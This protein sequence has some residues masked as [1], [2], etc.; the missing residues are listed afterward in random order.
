MESLYIHSKNRNLCG[1]FVLPT[2]TILKYI[3]RKCWYKNGSK[4]KW[5]RAYL[6]HVD[7]KAISSK[8]LITL[9]D[10]GQN[11]NLQQGE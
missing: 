9:K 1:T 2:G 5:S 8:L 7:G 6:T 4:T 10:V 3:S 11:I